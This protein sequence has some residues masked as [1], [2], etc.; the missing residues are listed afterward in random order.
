MSDYDIEYELDLLTKLVKIDTESNAKVGYE[1]CAKL[2]I[3]EARSLGLNIK[4]LDGGVEAGDSIS[5]PILIIEKGDPAFPTIL[6][7]THYDVV[8]PGDLSLWETNPFELVIK[9]DKAYGRGAADDKSNI[10]CILGAAKRIDKTRFHMRALITPDEEIGG[11]YGI[12]YAMNNKEN[13]VTGDACVVLDAG[14]EYVSLGA[15]GVV[16]GEVDV[17]GE[18]GHAGYPFKG[19]NAAMDLIKLGN[20]LCDFKDVREAK[21][22]VLNAAPSTGLDKVYGRF[23]ITMI[24]GGEKEN[25]IPGKAQLRFD[26]RL[27]PEERVQDAIEEFQT[28]FEEAKQEVGVDA[29]F[30]PTT[31]LQGYMTPADHWITQETLKAVTEAKG[32]SVPTAGE[33]GGNDGS[34]IAPKGI[35]TVS[36][37]TIREDTKFHGVNEFVWLEDIRTVR[38]ML[39]HLFKAEKTF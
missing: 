3:D 14:S 24:N 22:S 16:W 31:T 29:T 28:F 10:A 2:I 7:E 35:P 9:G 13:P 8:P 30:K 21:K 6:L 25:V 26:M 36:Y 17:V 33:L 4:E 15:S 27:L 11:Q 34:F 12:Q 39:V 32:V 37:G 18:Q 38:D 5:R 1:E 20:R 19:A 23:S